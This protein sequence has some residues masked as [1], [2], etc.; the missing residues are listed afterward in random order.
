MSFSSSFD[1]VYIMIHSVVQTTSASAAMVTINSDIC[2]PTDG[3]MMTLFNGQLSDASLFITLDQH[4]EPKMP[5]S[6]VSPNI[7]RD[8]TCHS[9]CITSS[10]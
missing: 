3:T 5:S 10:G 9:D 7:W 8:L 2:E 6:P 4:V 1:N